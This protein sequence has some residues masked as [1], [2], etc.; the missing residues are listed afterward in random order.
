MAYKIK[1]WYNTGFTATNIPDSEAT[2]NNAGASK[3]FPSLN[4]LSNEWLSSVIVKATKQETS[5]I[6]YVKIW[7]PSE[8]TQYSTWYYYVTAKS[9]QQ[10]GAIELSLTPIFELIAGGASNIDFIAGVLR[11][12]S[13]EKNPLVSMG[14]I[15][16]EYMAPTKPLVLTID[17]IAG[18]SSDHT[19]EK[20]V[21]LTATK[22]DLGAQAYCEDII[23]PIENTVQ[24][25]TGGDVT[26]NKETVGGALT[27]K[28]FILGPE[29]AGG[30][31][32]GIGGQF[33]PSALTPYYLYLGNQRFIDLG[34]TH[35][36]QIGAEGAILGSY[37]VPSIYIGTIAT[38]GRFCAMGSKE[39]NGKTVNGMFY[40]LG[41]TQGDDA[42]FVEGARTSGESIFTY[43]YVKSIQSKVLEY[44]VDYG[45]GTGINVYDL[46]HGSTYSYDNVV[47]D[48]LLLGD[49]NKYGIVTDGDD[50]IEVNPERILAGD[51]N[52][53]ISADDAS[54]LSTSI[55]IGSFADLR[56]DGK[57]YFYFKDLD[58]VQFDASAS[59][60]IGKVLMYA[61]AGQQ[62]QNAPI[63]WTDV[64]GGKLAKNRYIQTI[65]KQQ[66]SFLQNTSSWQSEA[67]RKLG[68][69]SNDS[70]GN[71]GT[72][73]V[74]STLAG[75]LSQGAGKTAET[76][77]MNIVS[78]LGNISGK[79]SSGFTNYA[80]I[81]QAGQSY[82]LEQSQERANYLSSVNIQIPDVSFSA[83]A[84]P[85]RDLTQS[86]ALMYKY[87]YSNEDV[88]RIDELLT[89]FGWRVCMKPKKGD[90]TRHQTFDYVEGSVEVK[91]ANSYPFPKWLADGLNIEIGEGMRIWHQSP[92]PITADCN[93]VKEA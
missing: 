29:D 81:V 5:L 44:N 19:P 17:R 78:L 24:T 87:S 64:S 83:G 71:I 4:I 34:I 73:S 68:E 22:V 84:M 37:Y 7:D 56:P 8:I 47:N 69:F 65:Q 2:L 40:G 80:N 53:Y 79:V 63:A 33:F 52:K 76:A 11:R 61:V 50:R 27:Y 23:I 90:L 1:A 43:N 86:S 10:P 14:Y 45:A 39:V 32:V 36:R 42:Q 88:Q 13:P 66:L 18:A 49:Y 67:S 9:P 91:S 16:D 72:S 25:G 48:C 58:G 3:E 77:G 15:P 38:S 28:T 26:I 35:L 62:W 31:N 46:K 92:I 82:A 74:Y 55:T 51:F 59:G 12:K 21:R 20:A 41:T 85:M 70:R 6:D 60:D 57:P 30:A 75:L 54:L 89:A 93:P